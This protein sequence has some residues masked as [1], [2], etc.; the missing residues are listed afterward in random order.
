[1]RPILER[2]LGGNY[3][4]KRNQMSIKVLD[5]NDRVLKLTGGEK[6]GG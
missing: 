2:Q 3:R 1:M 6:I 4:H 5:C